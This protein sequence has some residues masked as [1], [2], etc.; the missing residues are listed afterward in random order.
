M[1]DAKGWDVGIS[2]NENWG[3]LANDLEDIALP[4][5]SDLIRTSSMYCSRY[6]MNS[7][8]CRNWT[9]T[10]FSMLLYVVTCWEV[11][12][13]F[14]HFL[15]KITQHTE[16]P[17][18][19]L[20][21]HRAPFH[22]AVYEVFVLR[23]HRLLPESFPYERTRLLWSYVWSKCC[24]EMALEHSKNATSVHQHLRDPQ[25]PTMQPQREASRSF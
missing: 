13:L 15:F 8:L 25:W 21:R 4:R 7:S 22:R 6:R 17:R 16:L 14:L 10:C 9:A 5:R 2:T 20:F 11:Q 1:A 24:R 3:S 18:H 23:G 19:G 12:T